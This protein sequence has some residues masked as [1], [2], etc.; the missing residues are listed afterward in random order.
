MTSASYSLRSCR[1]TVSLWAPAITWKLVTIRPLSSHT[2]PVP[3]PR[4]ISSTL[5]LKKL[6]RRA[7]LVT[8]TTAGLALLKISVLFCSSSV[9]KLR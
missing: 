8:K 3:A 5:R 1:V 6:R 7:V 4:G 9:A 2:K